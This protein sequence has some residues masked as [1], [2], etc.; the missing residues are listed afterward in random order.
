[1]NV[2]NGTPVLSDF[3]PTQMF[4]KNC[5]LIVYVHTRRFILSWNYA[6]SFGIVLSFYFIFLS[7][8]QIDVC[9]FH[10]KGKFL[11]FSSYVNCIPGEA[12]VTLGTF[13]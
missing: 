11:K 8:M 7:N 10:T 5:L 13:E 6:F 2:L 12:V 9:F 4:T 3:F 1:M